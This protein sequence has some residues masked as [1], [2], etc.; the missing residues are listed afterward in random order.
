MDSPYRQAIPTDNDYKEV[1]SSF[2]QVHRDLTVNFGYVITTPR[3]VINDRRLVIMPK[4]AGNP[5]R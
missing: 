4:W 2:G 3:L 5:T 1:I